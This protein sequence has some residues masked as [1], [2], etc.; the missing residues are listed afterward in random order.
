[1][2][3]NAQNV[4]WTWNYAC[5]FLFTAGVT[6]N[7]RVLRYFLSC[8]HPLKSIKESGQ[9]NKEHFLNLLNSFTRSLHVYVDFIRKTSYAENWIL[10]RPK[11]GFLEISA[12]VC[13][14]QHTKFWGSL[15]YLQHFKRHYKKSSWFRPNWVINWSTS[16]II[17][18]KS[19]YSKYSSWYFN[20]F[21]S[22]PLSFRI[23][24]IFP[25]P[26]VHVWSYV[27][28]KKQDV[29]FTKMWEGTKKIK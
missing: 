5:G 13:D 4:F 21:N 8:D 7:F 12:K 28:D 19:G 6:H 11:F 27:C 10:L 15:N 17:M 29:N 14:L 9:K 3:Q 1:M 16:A 18:L 25:R 26:R 24:K 2:Y 23:G 22:M 20:K